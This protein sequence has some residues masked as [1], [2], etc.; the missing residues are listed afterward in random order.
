MEVGHMLAFRRIDVSYLNGID[1]I[2]NAFSKFPKGLTD[3]KS[4]T[5]AG[6]KVHYSTSS[7]PVDIVHLDYLY[8]A[9]TSAEL[10]LVLVQTGMH[11][12]H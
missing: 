5:F 1:V 2:V 7:P 10:V 12:K 9:A 6:H 3:I 8:A 4:P 11:F